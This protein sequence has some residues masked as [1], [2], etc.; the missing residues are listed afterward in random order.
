[1]EEGV[2]MQDLTVIGVEDGTLVAASD[3]GERYRI[4]VDDVVASRLKARRQESSEGPKVSPREIQSHIRGGMSAEDVAEVTGASLD[5]VERFVG[6]IMA[7]REHVVSS[8]LG[9]AVRTSAAVDPLGEPDTF[10]SVIR[11]RLASLGA[12]GERW[13]SWKD[14][15]LGWIVKLSFTADAIDHDARWE[16][17]PRKHSLAPQNPEAMTLSQQGEL[18]GGLIPRLRAVASGTPDDSR[19][20]SGQFTF[21]DDAADSPFVETVAI[22]RTSPSAGNPIQVDAVN[23]GEPRR[24]QNQTADL[25]EALRRRRGEREAAT[26]PVDDRDAGTTGP[27]AVDLPLAEFEALPGDTGPLG[28]T[29]ARRGR[30][31]MPSW[32]EIVF[33][34]RSDDDPA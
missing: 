12:T 25:L 31:A 17:E 13:A 30:A 5:Y 23:R 11:D 33:G 21:T 20:D 9:V 18:Q 29:A 10:G 4:A 6:P 22:G 34:A 16:Y 14:E 26:A 3:D 8:A 19:F 24:D 2:R 28:R 32:D 1:M 7:E 15:E 27:R